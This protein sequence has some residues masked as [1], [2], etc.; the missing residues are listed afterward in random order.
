MQISKRTFAIILVFIFVCG[1]FFGYTSKLTKLKCDNTTI[2]TA[3]VQATQKTDI[4]YIPKTNNEKT[5]VDIKIG[6]PELN[7]KI[8]GKD[9]KINKTDDE[10]FVLEKNK[11]SMN[12]NS[13]VAFDIKTETIDNTRRF[14]IGTQYGYSD[15]LNGLVMFPAFSILSFP[16]NG[17]I[18]GGRNN[19]SGGLIL[20][21]K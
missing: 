15:G 20:M 9:L 10:K 18:A 19:I 1:Y 3:T 5:D 12:Q 13:A 2:A 6:K 4:A 14:G 8:N 7:I 21:I 11:L 17:L 16:I